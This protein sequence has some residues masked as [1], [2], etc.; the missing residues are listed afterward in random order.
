M[1]AGLIRYLKA[2]F[3]YAKRK[4]LV[5]WDPLDGIRFLP[6]ETGL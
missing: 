3:N 5:D 6:M 4:R 1:M 2:S